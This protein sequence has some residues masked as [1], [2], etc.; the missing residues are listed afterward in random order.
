MDK[1]FPR[2][3][4]LMKVGG[5]TAAAPA[6]FFGSEDSWAK[7]RDKKEADVSPPEDL[8]REH[9]VLSRILLIYGEVGRRMREDQTL[10]ADVLAGCTGLIRRFIEDYHEK[11]EEEYL[12]PQFEKAG[13][14]VDLVRDLK[15]QHR[16]GRVLTDL[17]R[18]GA[19]SKDKSQWEPIGRNMYLFARMYRPHKAREDTVLFPATH[20]LF[21]REEFDKL[22]DRF[23]DREKDLFGEGGFERIVSEV[24]EMEKRLHLFEISR[25]TPKKS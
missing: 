18:E 25:F 3:V 23:E 1:S 9:G 19:A 20:S 14:Y 5:L 4:F 15:E 10:E 24:A 7:G 2:R 16:A 13:K 8:M 6:F 12:F 22:G 17:I 11:L 21:S